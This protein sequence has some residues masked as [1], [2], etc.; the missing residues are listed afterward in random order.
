VDI[1]AVVAAHMSALFVKLLD[2]EIVIEP[3]MGRCGGKIL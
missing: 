3:F 2:A 1:P